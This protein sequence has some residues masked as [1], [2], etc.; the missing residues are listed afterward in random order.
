MMSWPERMPPSNS[1]SI[2]EPTASAI[3]GSAEIEDGA[4]SSWRPP[5]F[6]TTSAAAPVFAAMRASSTSR[7]PLRMSLPGQRLAIHSTSFQFSVGSNWLGGPAATA[8]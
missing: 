1:T 8:N 6:D 7:M 4:P 2:D 5:W 3:G